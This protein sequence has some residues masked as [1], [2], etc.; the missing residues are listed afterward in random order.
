MCID[1]SLRFQFQLAHHTRL[2]SRDLRLSI[3][4]KQALRREARDGAGQ[5]RSEATVRFT[6]RRVGACVPL[7]IHQISKLAGLVIKPL[8]NYWLA[9]GFIEMPR[10][11]PL[12]VDGSGKRKA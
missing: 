3:L 8:A 10:D 6:S 5:E 1:E 11:L 12:A 4:S 9:I 2:S 7:T